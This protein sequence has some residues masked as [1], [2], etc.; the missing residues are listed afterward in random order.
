MGIIHFLGMVFLMMIAE[1]C[2]T[3]Y[4]INTE[5]RSAFKAGLWCALYVLL[6]DV[7][8]ITYVN[9]TTLIAATVIGA[10]L[11]TYLINKYWKFKG[12]Q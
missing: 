12:P 10:F 4:L 8:V 9:R 1:A 2:C 6:T 7:I 5:K 11:G 3:L